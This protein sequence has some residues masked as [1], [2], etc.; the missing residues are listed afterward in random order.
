MDLIIADAL[1]DPL[2]GPMLRDLFEDEWPEDRRGFALN[3]A[4]GAPPW[5]P[6]LVAVWERLDDPPPAGLHAGAVYWPGAAALLRRLHA[7]YLAAQ[8]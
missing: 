6:S 5:W 3:I 2:T 8:E 7:E 4:L 1:R